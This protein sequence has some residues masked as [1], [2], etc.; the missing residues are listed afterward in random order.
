MIPCSE[1]KGFYVVETLKA[2]SDGNPIESTA[3]LHGTLNANLVLNQ[4]LIRMGTNSDYLNVCSVGSGTRT[5]T[6]SDTGLQS[7]MASSSAAS[8]SSNG[9]QVYAPY[10]A[11]KRKTFTFEVG[12][13]V[14]I[15][16]ELAIGWGS[17]DGE[18]Y[19]RAL[20]RDGNGN[21]AA[22]TVLADEALRVTYEHRY[23]PILQDTTG[24][25]ELVGDIEGVFNYTIRASMVST[26]TYWVADRAQNY[27]GGSSG[28]GTA[29]QPVTA[30]NGVI[31]RINEQPTGNRLTVSSMIGTT[32][33]LLA[34]FSFGA[35]AG[36]MNLAGGIKS[37]SFPMG[38]GFYQIEFTPAIPKDATNT[39]S[40]QFSHSWGGR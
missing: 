37:L 17:S 32:D 22:I 27:G 14:G 18:I 3:V 4:G 11:W 21:P 13:V 8:G 38:N 16:G 7:I 6:A 36:Q 10:Y 12:E 40:L 2:D 9:A 1:P 34:R 31:G 23:Y 28:A 39:L 26:G 30:Y 25:V 5:P 19:S 33:G 15:V 24:V 20:V 29:S 35:A